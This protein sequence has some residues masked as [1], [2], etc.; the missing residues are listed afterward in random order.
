MP[1]KKPRIA[2]LG[3]GGTIA[4]THNNQTHD[5]GYMPA[6]LPVALLLSQIPQIYDFAEIISEQLCQIA[7]QDITTDIWLALFRRINDLLQNDF[8][9]VVITHGTD[10]LEETAYFLHL[11]LKTKKPIVLVGS[12]RPASAL[13]ADGPMNLYS[14][15]RLATSR[16]AVGKGVLVCL[17]NSVSSA[18]DVAKTNT[19]LP[20]ALQSPD[21]G[22]MGYVQDGIAHL[23]KA[24]TRRH[25][26]ATEFDLSGIQ[27]LPQVDI[28]YGYAQS[29]PCLVE[30][31]ISCGTQGIIYAGA[32]NG[33]ISKDCCTALLKARQQG[34]VV[35]RSSRVGAGRI[36]RNGEVN[37]DTYGFITADNLSP[38]KARVL[39]MLA[40]TRTQ[41][42]KQIQHI[43]ERY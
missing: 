30:C 18:R 27:T 16:T 32:G 3:T 26:F 13:S 20:S 17:N 2:V 14:A 33:S 1:R 31:L 23:Y 21:L 6:I 34:V 24:S 42:I 5:T 28:L 7:S 12:M 15:I 37:D 11:T 8:D 10:T 35:V 38:Q 41:N 39:L 19:A 9:G 40:L 36:A 29:R 22:T 4:G 25:T 43:F